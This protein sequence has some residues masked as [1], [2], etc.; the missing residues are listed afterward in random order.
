MRLCADNDTLE[1]AKTLLKKIA[2][3]TV[4]DLCITFPLSAH[5]AS[6]K[7]MA[8]VSFRNGRGVLGGYHSHQTVHGFRSLA[9]TWANEQLVP[10]PG[11]STWMR[12]YHKD[13]VELQLAHSN[14]DEVRDAYNSA[15]Y[16]VPRRGMMQDWADYLD[17]CRGGEEGLRLVDAA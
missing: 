7:E 13:W 16:L 14:D 3:P 8:Q 15:E 17:R 9:S 12:K 1:S 11:A 6:W 4:L 10:L 2:L 5:N